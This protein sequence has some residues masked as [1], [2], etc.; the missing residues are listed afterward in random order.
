MFY[1]SNPI[2]FNCTF[3]EQTPITS[4]DG[5]LKTHVGITCYLF[6]QYFLALIT[7]LTVFGVHENIVPTGA[8]AAEFSA[9]A[10][11]G[12]VESLG[13]MNRYPIC[14]FFHSFQLY[15][16]MYLEKEER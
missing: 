4:Q 13:S 8:A 14:R 7:M 9:R 6:V 15:V 12:F 3:F 2:F 5:T 10:L 11:P 16:I 1:K